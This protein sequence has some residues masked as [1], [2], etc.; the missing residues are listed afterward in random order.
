MAGATVRPLRTARQS[1]HLSLKALAGK[2]QVSRRTILRAEQGHRLNPSTVRLLCDFFGRSAKELGLEIRGTSPD[3]PEML[4]LPRVGGPDRQRTS[5]GG[6]GS[7]PTPDAITLSPTPATD[8][9]GYRVE[10]ALVATYRS[11]LS[12]YA[13]IDNLAGPLPLLTVLPE[14][15]AF[16]ERLLPNI[17]GDLRKELLDVAARSAEF[18][19]WLCQDAGDF[20]AAVFWSD[21]ALNYALQRGDSHL[22]SY[23]L[24]RKSNIASDAGDGEGALD[25]ARAALREWERLTPRL[26]AVALRQ[27]AHGHALRGDVS[28]V[29]RSIDR[30]MEQVIDERPTDPEFDLTTYCTIGYVGM[31]AASCWLQ[32]GE[33]KRAIETYEQRI[34]SWAP[35]FKRDL[36]ICLGRLAVAHAANRDLEEAWDVGQR[37]LTIAQETRSART[38]RELTRLHTHLDGSAGLRAAADLGRALAELTPNPLP[39][40]R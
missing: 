25:Y 12:H 17:S 4:A 22:I 3:G 14:Q 21:R 32:V 24:M 29:A 36:G 18:T 5:H 20:Q 19:G 1:Q 27:E 34:R 16:L 40:S 37:A 26:R 31:E 8:T 38:I 9:S 15:V 30:A 13:R 23:V 10:P 39:S 11:V 33:P 28:E 6:P 35:E 7:I 2:T